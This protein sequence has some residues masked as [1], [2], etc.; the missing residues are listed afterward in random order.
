M[1]PT[2]LIQQIRAGTAPPNI[3][4]FA[5]QGMLPVPEDDLIPVQVFLCKDE[6]PAIAS[7]A[8][9]SLQKISD[10]TWSRLIEK[11]NPDPAIIQFCLEQNSISLALREKVILNHS[12]PDETI[13]QIAATQSGTLLDLIIN[14][15][16]R[17]LRSPE[18]ISALELNPFLNFD[19]KRRLEEFK[20]EFVFK[21]KRQE[22]EQPLVPVE[23]TSVEDI[24][25]Q[26]PNLD[27]EA[28]R[29]LQEADL[30][31]PPELTDE[32]VEQS[33]KNLLA[34]DDLSQISE[35]TLSIYQRILQMPHK[36][37]IRIAL[38]GT[39]E[40]RNILI[41][42]S[43]RQIASMVLRSPKLTEGEI[44]NYAQMRNIDSELLRQ[45]GQSR[46]FLKKYSVIHC[47]VKNP[48]TPSPVSLNLLKLLREIDLRNLV[49]DRN[50]PDVIRRQAKH[51]YEQKDHR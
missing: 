25:A 36:E 4:Q 28:V 44:E 50:I 10:E 41:R 6:E 8:F 15:Q 47:L 24:L 18:I 2:S 35:D 3:R 32:Q 11:R 14:N 23:Q 9:H 5:A 37:K 16:V 22:R 43:S 21:K 39:K 38:L 27:M 17:L 46:D 40:E 26:I 51:I 7:A 12:I 42:D 13:R 49:R 29:I 20:T 1:N 33:M 45:M 31:P 34:T 30:N 19:Q 48:K